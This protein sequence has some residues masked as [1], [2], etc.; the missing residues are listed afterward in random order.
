[1]NIHIHGPCSD[2]EC[3][4]TPQTQIVSSI[5]SFAWFLFFLGF[6][7]GAMGRLAPTRTRYQKYYLNVIHTG[8][9][10]NKNGIGV[11]N[12]RF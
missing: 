6:Q 5:A 10:W 4:G 9:W 11:V 7:Q 2:R 8:F 1:M 3:I 12:C